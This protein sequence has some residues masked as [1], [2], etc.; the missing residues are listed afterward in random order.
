[1]TP[2]DAKPVFGA[3]VKELGAALGDLGIDDR[4]GETLTSLAGV[5]VDL[6]LDREG[7]G[8]TPD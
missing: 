4:D 3:M 6:E 2:N 7:S 1:M 5:L 8:S